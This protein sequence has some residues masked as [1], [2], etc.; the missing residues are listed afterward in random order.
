MKTKQLN[1]LTLEE[2]PDVELKKAENKVPASFYE[3]YSAF[4]NTRG[5]TV[6]LGIKEI[7]KGRNEITGVEDPSRMKTDILS[8]L[9][10]KQK[11]SCCLLEDEDFEIIETENGKKVIKISIREASPADKPVY[12][13][14]SI[15]YSYKRR[16]DGDFALKSEEISYFFFSKRE[17][18]YD[19]M[20]NEIGIEADS[21]NQET[22]NQFRLELSEVHP[23]IANKASSQ[24][25]FLKRIGAYVTQPNGKK[26]ISNAA[27]LFFG[28]LP[29]ILRLYP[30]YFV[31]Y[32]RYEA[33]VSEKWSKRITSDDFSTPGNIYSLFCRIRAE[34]KPFLP[35]PFYR[36][37]WTNL[38]GTDIQKAVL[39][40]IANAFS[41]SAFILTEPLIFRQTPT[42]FFIHNPG[43]I[44]TGLEQAK[45]GGIS[46]PLNP[47][48]LNFFRFINAAEKAGTGIP[49][50]YDICR[51][52]SYPEPRLYELREREAT[53]LFISF[54]ALPEDT[55]SK[56]SKEKIL[57]CLSEHPEGMGIAEIA[58]TISMSVTQTTSNVRELM[59]MGLVEDNK[60][61]RKGRKIKLKS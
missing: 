29:D 59:A 34:I 20:V 30:S 18:K 1:L 48:V 54:K 41:N 7:K 44:G 40:G 2:G 5:G 33:G 42:S 57:A 46:D 28:E 9:Q 12:I 10:N 16:G 35:N 25:E 49:K 17:I 19:T 45:Q 52:Y 61:P 22:I 21:L 27:I 53:E 3:T 4:A 47:G 50:I 38:D 58:E 43:R 39:E 56:R 8:T 32:Q 51:R 11:C 14:G 24:I 26:G 31:D 6:Y 15:N 55:P 23:E 36:E 37:N 60:L 13:K